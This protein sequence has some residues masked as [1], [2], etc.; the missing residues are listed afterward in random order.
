MYY[1]AAYYLQKAYA[2]QLQD[3]LNPY[4]E[5]P[6]YYSEEL[7]IEK[8]NSVKNQ[9][10]R[11]A[12]RHKEITGLPLNWYGTYNSAAQRVITRLKKER[13]WATA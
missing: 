5:L 7:K 3:V 6:D 11:L 8:N 10:K 1:T 2:V 13:A 9:L 4:D 12:E